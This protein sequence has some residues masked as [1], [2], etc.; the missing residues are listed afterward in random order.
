MLGGNEDVV[1]TAGKKGPS[2]D[3]AFFQLEVCLLLD[4][5]RKHFS[6]LLQLRKSSI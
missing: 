5:N 4:S 2:T 3:N 6:L 1:V